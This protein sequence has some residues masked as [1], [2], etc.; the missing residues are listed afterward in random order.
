MT[1]YYRDVICLPPS[2]VGGTR[3]IPIPRGKQRAKLAELGL[4]G[5]VTLSSDMSEEEIFREIRSA[6]ADA[7]GKDDA[8]PFTFLQCAGSGAK[9]LSSPSLSTSFQWTVPEVI[10]GEIMHIHTSRKRA[11]CG[12]Y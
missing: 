11:D 7:M 12:G 5:K 8:F 6:F 10:N 1:Q 9:S 2:L 4:Q 3:I